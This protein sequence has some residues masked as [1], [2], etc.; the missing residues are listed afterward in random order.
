[1][2]TLLLH[3]ED[4]PRRGRWTAEKWDCIVDLGKSSQSTAVAWQQLTGSAVIRLDDYRKSIEDPR[5]VGQILR[6]WFGTLL[7]R[8]G[9]DWWELTSIFV[10]P[11][12]EN[13]IALRRMVREVSLDGELFATRPDWPVTGV[14]QLLRREIRSFS[15]ANG[16]ASARMRRISRALR[17]LSRT[18]IIEILWD[19]YDADY[20]WRARVAKARTSS[21][22]P[23]VLLPSAYTNVSRAA[24]AY[25]RL[26]PEQDFLL[27]ATRNSGLRFECPPNVHVAHLAEYAG[28]NGEALEFANLEEGW[29]RLLPQLAEVPEMAMLQDAGLLAPIRDLIRSGLAVRDSWLRVFE[30]EP[31]TAV[32]CGDD[33]NWFTRLP[34]MLAAQRKL[35]TVDF[36]HGAFDGRFLLKN[37][38]SDM[39]LAKNEM[40]RDYLLRVCRLPAERVAV[41]GIEGA[42]G[43][44]KRQ[45]AAG[46]K[47]LF[48]SEPYENAGSRPE[49]IYRELLPAL[50]RTAEQ[51]G[52]RIVVKL[53]PFENEAERKRLI[54]LALGA[55]WRERVEI[56]SGPLTPSLLDSAWFGIAVES[57]AVV[58]CVRHSVP[59]F[60]CAWLASTPF[61]YSEQYAR[62][63]VGRLLRSRDE[64]S[65]IPGMLAEGNFLSGA[66][67]LD[68]PPVPE[69]LRKLLIRQESP[70]MSELR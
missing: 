9:L 28:R 5:L 14:E 2:K 64:I 41:S 56:A 8:W 52:R 30:Q 49:E 15:G 20:R 37:L 70:A 54:E 33:S 65:G 67:A 1:M 69:L 7:D 57:S 43:I 59:C 68:S 44:G 58:D 18:Q 39:Y 23:V 10:D 50:C 27:V 3:P 35:P 4:S 60:H 19:K 48:F 45:A 40:E 32:L 12:L 63:G 55:S 31:V 61:G 24:S 11:D 53:H 47:V 21:G 26:L 16:G 25:A 66:G 42:S 51:H 29:S 17:R 13:A 62:Y 46:G 36:H 34:V 22:R 6:Q 38:S